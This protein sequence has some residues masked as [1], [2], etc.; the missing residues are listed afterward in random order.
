MRR[1]PIAYGNSCF[2]K[3]WP[4]KV[5]TFDEL[6]A[7]LEHTI[8]TTESADEYPKLP[9]VERDRIKDKVGFCRRPAS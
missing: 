9:K 2:A 5:I 8:H 4:N 6:C 7:R 3:T 1:F